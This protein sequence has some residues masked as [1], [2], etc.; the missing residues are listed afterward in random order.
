[1]STPGF[2]AQA[3]LYQVNT[4][5]QI[6]G[7][8]KSA[9][10]GVQPAANFVSCKCIKP[11]AGHNGHCTCRWGISNCTGSSTIWY[12]NKGNVTDVETGHSCV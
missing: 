8:H 10:S 11:G 7:D 2:S 3:A 6:T 12:D 4:V 1:M 9:A 5:Y